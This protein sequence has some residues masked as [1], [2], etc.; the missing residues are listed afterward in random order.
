[1][2]R[3]FTVSNAA[4]MSISTQAPAWPPSTTWVISLYSCPSAVRWLIVKDQVVHIRVGDKP[5]NNS[6]DH[7]RHR[8][9][10]RN[11][12]IRVEIK[13]IQRRHLDDGWLLS[14]DCPV[15]CIFRMINDALH[16]GRSTVQLHCRP[17]W[18]SHVGNESRL[19]CFTGAFLKKASLPQHSPDRTRRVGPVYANELWT[20]SRWSTGGRWPDVLNLPREECSKI[21]GLMICFYCIQ[22]V[23]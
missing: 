7:H 16:I 23:S 9:E 1:M 10:V 2:I 6:L 21:F 12:P 20:V 19:Q 5:M 13:W 4:D 15:E 18:C 8:T 14:S 11:R 17:T 3:W 22:F